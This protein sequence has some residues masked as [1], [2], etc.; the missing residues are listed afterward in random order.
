MPIAKTAKA[1][2]TAKPSERFSLVPS[3]AQQEMVRALT[4]LKSS[5]SRNVSG[6]EIAEAA[7][8]LAAG[9][10][11]PVILACSGRGART[12]RKDSNLVV[13][14]NAGTN[15]RKLAA[16]TVAAI[17]ALLNAALL[18]KPQATPAVVCAGKLEPHLEAQ[19]DY[20]AAFCFAARHKLPI[21]Y[22]VA[23]SLVPGQSQPLDLRTLYSEFGIPLFSV[24]ANDAIA[25]YRVATEALH[26]ARH[27]RG[28]CVI[29]ALAVPPPTSG[30]VSPLE[31][32]A[33]YMERHG[34]LPRGALD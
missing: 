11:S 16:A 32:L 7:V 22:I 13:I 14:K 30:A 26:N 1:S 5:R 19:Q 18:A 10:Q 20:R 31:L 9:E 12:V 6:S 2:K 23:N 15:G 33:A 4:A 3:A 21:L 29:E 27:L 24:D 8:C 17:D 25:A 34:N 28:P